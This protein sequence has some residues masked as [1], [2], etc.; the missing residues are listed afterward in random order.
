MNFWR[1]PA[2]VGPKH[3]EKIRAKIRATSVQTILANNPRRNP[4]KKNRAKNRAKKSVQKIRAKNP[5]KKSVQKIRAK[6]PCRKSVQ[7]SVQKIC[8]KE[9]RANGFPKVTLQIEKPNIKQENLFVLFFCKL[10][11]ASLCVLKTLRFKTL[12][13]RGTKGKRPMRF[14]GLCAKMRCDL[15]FKTAI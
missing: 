11:L 10:A 5:C 9:T 12:R 3:P 4:R 7:K 13:F 8:A 15:R 14:G 6:N 1:F 2:S